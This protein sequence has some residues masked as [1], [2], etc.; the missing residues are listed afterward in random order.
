MQRNWN[1]Y[2]PLKGA[3][4]MFIAALFTIAKR[5]KQPWYP[6]KVTASTKPGVYIQRDI[7]QPLKGRKI[8]HMKQHG[9]TLNMLYY[10]K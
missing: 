6:V 9:R 7:T 5:C 8:L 3:A 1:L 10:M 4:A 2:A